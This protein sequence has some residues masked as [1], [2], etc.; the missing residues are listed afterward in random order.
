MNQEEIL[1]SIKLGKAIDLHT[2]LDKGIYGLPSDASFNNG[3]D[4]SGDA[5]ITVT[6]IYRGD[7][8]TLNSGKFCS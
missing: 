1:Q 4:F 3:P 6:P 7:G 8:T 2:L 5:T